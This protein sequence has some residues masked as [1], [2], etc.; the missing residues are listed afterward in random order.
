MQFLKKK[1]C[2]N[3][4]ISLWEI[5][6][7][8]TLCVVTFDVISVQINWICDYIVVVLCVLELQTLLV[9]DVTKIWHLLFCS[10]N[11]DYLLQRLCISNEKVDEKWIHVNSIMDHI[12][13]QTSYF[14]LAICI[15][16]LAYQFLISAIITIYCD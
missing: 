2:I 12:Q 16:E 4:S 1:Q 7:I 13:W 10:C 11:C 3:A 9:M 6:S 8:S 5:L 15:I 14:T